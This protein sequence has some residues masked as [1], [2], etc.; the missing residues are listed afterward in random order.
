MKFFNKGLKKIV[1][2]EGLLRRLKNIEDKNEEQLKIIKNKT[3]NIKE[4]TG[5][6]EEPL[7]LEAQ[8][9]I[10]EIRITQTDV[11][12]RKLKFRGGNNATYNFSN[13]KT[14][15]QLF[16]ELY[17]QKNDNRSCKTCAR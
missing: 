15:K 13:N 5:F 8:A 12:Y 6:F 2:K 11:D 7:S 17:L 4:V 16:R 1:K 9:L 14:F 10:E 3:A